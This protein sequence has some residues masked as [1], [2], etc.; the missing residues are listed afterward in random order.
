M[1]TG[2]GDV[3]RPMATADG[4][5]R[6]ADIRWRSSARGTPDRKCDHMAVDGGHVGTAYIVYTL[7]RLG[8]AA[9]DPT[10]CQSLVI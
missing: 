2:R 9:V 3:A 7:R 4:R 5:S 8:R 6:I 10:Y 1:A